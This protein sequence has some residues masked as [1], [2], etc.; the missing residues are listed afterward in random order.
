MVSV[1]NN[2]M[3]DFGKRALLETLEHLEAAGI[4]YAGA[5]RKPGRAYQ[6]VVLRVRDWSIALFAVTHIWN[7]PPYRKHPGRFHVAWADYSRLHRSLKRARREHDVVLVSYHGGGEYIDRQLP[8]T[9]QFA[10]AVMRAGV[11][12]LIGH[13]PHVTQGV[14]F[15]GAR[16][17]LFSLGNLVFEPFVSTET[18]RGFMARL[19]FDRA[20][21]GQPAAVQLCPYWIGDRYMPR[22]LT[23]LGDGERAALVAW[24]RQRVEQTS[25]ALGR[26]WIGEFDARGCAPVSARQ[27]E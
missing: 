5:S 11:D 24:F 10:A 1:A 21:P 12:A 2:H 17:V 25:R 14:Q 4:A 3:W 13:H 22:P 26:L 16:P 6:P 9:R 15:H 19:V 27:P 20:R 8:V 18:K 7:Q 23:A